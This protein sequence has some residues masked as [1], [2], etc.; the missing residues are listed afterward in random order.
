MFYCWYFINDNSTPNTN[1]ENALWEKMW[2]KT[3][4]EST[5]MLL[6]F[7]ESPFNMLGGWSVRCE[8]FMAMWKNFN[9]MLTKYGQIQHVYISLYL[10]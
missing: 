4:Y 2:Y 8:Y 7:R 9:C 1:I 6:N 3:L 10:W 5:Q